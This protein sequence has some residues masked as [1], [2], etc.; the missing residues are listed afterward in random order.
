MTSRTRR[1]QA[2]WQHLVEQ[3]ASS[4]LNA[5]AFCKQHKLCRKSFY[6]HRKML[7]ENTTRLATSRFIQ[8]QAKPAPVPRSTMVVLDYRQARLQ[9]P[10][11]ID[12]VWVADLMKALP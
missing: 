10:T 9:L 11:G 5:A 6:H 8:V 7:N 2:Q 3:Q 4:D 1:S 12:P